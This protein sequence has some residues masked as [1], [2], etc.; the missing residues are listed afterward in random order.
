MQTTAKNDSSVKAHL[1]LAEQRKVQQDLDRL[2][3][4]S[5]DDEFRNA[6]VQGLRRCSA[7]GPEYEDMYVGATKGAA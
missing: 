5:H 3:V 6:A 4:R 2:R 1:V 7:Q